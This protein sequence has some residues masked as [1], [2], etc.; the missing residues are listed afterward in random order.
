MQLGMHK[1]TAMGRGVMRH[2]VQLACCCTL[3]Q[4]GWFGL[5]KKQDSGKTFKHIGPQRLLGV[6]AASIGLEVYA[7]A[8][9]RTDRTCPCVFCLSRLSVHGLLI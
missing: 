1:R 6:E 4:A 5:G 8:L 7:A 9:Q 2:V 3:V